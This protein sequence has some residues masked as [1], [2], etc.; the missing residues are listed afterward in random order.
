[1]SKEKKT[2]QLTKKQK[3]ING[4]T[5]GI[6]AL[7]FLLTLYVLASASISASKNGRP[8]VFGYHIG[9]VGTSSMEPTIKTYS[10]IFYKDTDFHNVEVGQIIVFKNIEEGSVVFGQDIVHRAYALYD[11]EG[12]KYAWL[13]EDMTTSTLDDK[14]HTLAKIQTK[15]DNS[16]T[17]SL[18][19]AMF[20]TVDNF[21]GKLSSH[22]YLFGLGKLRL[23]GN[24]SIVFILLLICFMGVFISALITIIKTILLEKERKAK[25]ITEDAKK[26]QIIDEYLKQQNENKEEN[27]SSD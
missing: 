1:M 14:E 4:I 7:I 12:V 15:G 2:K 9:V 26:Q 27:T 6:C 22:N 10:F 16:E 11:T 3:I 23:K 8:K 5:N 24:G 21:Y 25:E 13:N 17:N 20:V 18:P 19:D